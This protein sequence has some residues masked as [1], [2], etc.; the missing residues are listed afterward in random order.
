M[1]APPSLTEPLLGAEDW[2][3]KRKLHLDEDESDR[4]W[5]TV[6]LRE[7]LALAGPLIAVNVLEYS[8]YLVSIMFAGRLGALELASAAL[9]M[10]FTSATGLSLLLGMGCA[11][12][13]LCGQAFGARNHRMV[14]VYMQRGMVILLLTSVP[15]AV[16]WCNLTRILLAI[17]QDAEIARKSGEYA[18]YLVPSLF[19]YAAL[20]AVVKFLQ[21]QS[22]VGVMT[23]SST[24]TVL[25]FHIPINYLMIFRLGFGFRGAAI[26]SSVSNWVN[27]L[28]LATYIK[29]SPHCTKTWTGFSRE[30]FRDLWVLI[31]LAVPSALMVCLDGWSFELVVL[32]SGLLPNP[33]LET[34]A[35]TVCLTTA[36]VMYMIPYGIGAA[37]STRVSNDLGA[38]N[39]RGARRAVAVS[40]GLAAVECIAVGLFL[41]SVRNSW[42]FLYT[43]DSDVAHYVARLMPLL[44]CHVAVDA[45][46]G[47]LSGV[48]RG[49]GWQAVGAA[50]NL[51]SYYL[52]GMP[53]GALLAFRFHWNDLGFWVGMGIGD[54][55]Q[56]V[57]LSIVIARTDW[58]QQSIRAIGEY[59]PLGD[60]PR[61]P[62][63]LPD[64]STAIPSVVLK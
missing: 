48:V 23:L 28:I 7:Q 34:A 44:A 45:I 43:N 64:A 27:L 21:A 56:V 38:G 12:E 6:E 17:G 53:I 54:T 41:F 51:G 63:R 61:K 18:F 47:I 32:L 40:L 57:I 25:F 3:Q 39:P 33:Q 10:S 5:V 16:V 49:G 62:H 20:Q 8:L 37:T 36:T 11:L 59:L 15:V 24:I 2:D 22:L 26:A 42:P 4:S 58:E 1:G 29:F 13:T 55:I 52:F 50:A 14:G 31:K 19:A 30:A 35:F 60:S 9:A 46:Q